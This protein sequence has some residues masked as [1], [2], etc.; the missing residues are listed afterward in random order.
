LKTCKN[1]GIENPNDGEYCEACKNLMESTED[2]FQP[3]AEFKLDWS[4]LFATSLILMGLISKFLD[5]GI[6][7][8]FLA[9]LMAAVFLGLNFKDKPNFLRNFFLTF[10]ISGV[11]VSIFFLPMLLH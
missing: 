4:A 7:G 2:P 5:F 9:G 8:L 6:R 3:E 11:I 10:L 1:C